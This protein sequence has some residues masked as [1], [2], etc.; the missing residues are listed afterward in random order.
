MTIIRGLLAASLLLL[1]S[2]VAAHANQATPAGTSAEVALGDLLLSQGFSRATRPGAPVAGGFLTITN[3]GMQADTLVGAS[4]PVAG[5][6]EVHEMALQD[7]VMKMRELPDGLP[8][9]AG[10]TVVLKPGGYHVMFMQLKQP[11]V[12][13][14]T[15]DVTLTFAKAGEVTIPLAIGAPDAETFEGK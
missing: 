14:R 11:L 15:V 6:M 10:E 5:H 2:P 12:E 3:K 4:S 8:I 9:P 1:A 13:G 7:G